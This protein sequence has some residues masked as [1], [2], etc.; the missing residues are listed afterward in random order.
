MSIIKISQ[1]FRGNNA[2]QLVIAS[3]F[4]VA[5]AGAVGLGLL[6]K[7][8]IQAATIRDCS[9]NS[10]DFKDLNGGCGAASPG[11]FVADVNGNNPSDLKPIY[12]HFGLAPSEYTRFVQTARPG[13]ALTNGQIVVDGAV[14]A[15]NA[16]SIGRTPF[17]YSTPYKIGANTFHK[18]A[19]T[20]VL[21]QNL[22]VMVMFD[23]NGKMEFAVLNACGN[24]LNGNP[25]TPT[26]SCDALRREPVTGKAN[27]YRFNTSATAGNGAKIAKVVYDFGDGSAPVTQA[28][29]LTAVTHTFT[30]TSNVTVT[31]YV[32]LPGGGTKVIA[33]TVKCSN[34][35]VVTPPPAPFYACT[36][37]TPAVLN[38]KKTQ[39]RFTVKT[40]QGNGAT[41]KDADFTLDGASTVTGVTTK[42]AQGNIYK[43]YTFAADGKDHTVVVKVNFNVANGVQSKT[44]QA[45]VTSGKQ[46]MC[47][48]PGK[49]HLPV[50]SPECVEN[51]PIAGKTHLPKNSPDCGEVLTATTELPKTGMG[52]MVGLFAGTST[53]GAVAHRV[54]MSRRHRRS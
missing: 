2:K 4:V 29:P 19:H 14:V 41:L 43:E 36:V 34:K 12:D 39:F 23:A 32:S 42:D 45:K 50:D 48:V 7:Q 26:Y 30:K 18:S 54:F 28:N 31:V 10:I 24:P 22:P 53:L 17:S 35:V 20:Q 37:L 46:P 21:K 15:S 52:S 33:P 8:K 3:A 6:T 13:M 49:E 47:T 40:S 44:C 5:L 51:C 16:W 27:T 11:E 9:V 1:H 25:V 38:D